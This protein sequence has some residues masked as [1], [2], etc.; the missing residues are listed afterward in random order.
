[1]DENGEEDDLFRTMALSEKEHE[2]RRFMFALVTRTER[3][4]LSRRW[5]AVNLLFEEMS[6]TD[7]HKLT[8][9]A[10][11]TLSTLNTLVMNEPKAEE[12]CRVFYLRL[13]DYRKDRLHNS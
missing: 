3:A 10:R 12:I 8:G 6:V 5:R 1:M 13:R 7:I 11:G 9:I 2:I 4:M